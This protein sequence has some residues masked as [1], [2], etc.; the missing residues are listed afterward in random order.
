[1]ALVFYIFAMTVGSDKTSFK[2]PMKPVEH[3]TKII[4]SR[5]LTKSLSFSDS[6][7]ALMYFMNC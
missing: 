2:L 7:W 4:F 6:I 3:L 1:M 5:L